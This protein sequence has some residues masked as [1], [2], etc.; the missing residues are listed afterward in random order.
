MNT[1]F[2]TTSLIILLL[3]MNT[4][5]APALTM[6]QVSDIC[7][8]SSGKCSDHPIIRAYI[9]GALDLLATLNE[10]TNYLEKVY[11]KDPKA[12]FDIQ[13]IIHFMKQQSKQNATDNAMLLFVRYFEAH[14]GC[15]E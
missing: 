1:H 8:S 13:A 6:K 12:L 15:N 7:Q 9:G 4:S 10:R 3:M 11:C 5:N 14:G 2:F